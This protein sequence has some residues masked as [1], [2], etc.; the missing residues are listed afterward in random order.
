VRPR[1]DGRPA[2]LSYERARP[3]RRREARAAHTRQRLP[4]G[5]RRR[6]ADCRRSGAATPATT[7]V[8]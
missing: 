1:L 4:A 5:D 3:R 7:A 6:R 2:G 8:A